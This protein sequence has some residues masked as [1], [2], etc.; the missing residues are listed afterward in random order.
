MS[1]SNKNLICCPHCHQ[2]F[3]FSSI[4]KTHEAQMKEEFR[5]AFESENKLLMENWRKEKE[6]ELLSEARKKAEAAAQDELAKLATQLSAKQK[7]SEDLGQQLTK[8]KTE[9]D[10]QKS[11]ILARAKLE[12]DEKHADELQKLKSTHEQQLAEKEKLFQ[13]MKK[14]IDTAHLSGNQISQQIR[15]EVFEDRVEKFLRES[16]PQDKFERASKGKNGADILHSVTNARGVEMGKIYWEV[17][18][19]KTFDS[20]FPSKLKNDMEKRGA[21]LGII[22][23]HAPPSEKQR[24]NFP[25]DV[26]YIPA[27]LF[28]SLIPCI[29]YLH[30]RRLALT[31]HGN[32]SKSAEIMIL[33]YFNSTRF[34]ELIEKTN[35]DINDELQQIEKDRNSANLSCKKRLARVQ[36]MKDSF[37]ELIDSITNAIDSNSVPARHLKMVLDSQT[38]EADFETAEEEDEQVKTMKR[39]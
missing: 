32:T 2:S 24:E 28:E 23:S 31:A 11:E 10:Q 25:E 12:A 21:S 35:L 7:V 39:H 27:H 20:S 22:I 3:D 13:N 30:E 1:N 36:S 33:K 18:N 9:F 16:Y 15:G 26:R 29:R 6:K 4:L 38:V 37:T 17:K 5:K 19:T 34:Q 8:L 14:K